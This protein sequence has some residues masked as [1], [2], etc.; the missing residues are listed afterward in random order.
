M[1]RF[2]DCVTDR[3]VTIERAR[4]FVENPD[5]FGKQFLTKYL[6]ITTSGTTGTHGVFLIIT[7]VLLVMVRVWCFIADWLAENP[8]TAGPLRRYGRL[9][10][11]FVLMGIGLT[12]LVES[13]ALSH[14]HPLTPRKG[15]SW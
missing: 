11:P 5:L 13:G 15:L 4:P 1:T 10:M 2:N 8:V 6:V 9:L 3:E 14:F 12:I 7:A